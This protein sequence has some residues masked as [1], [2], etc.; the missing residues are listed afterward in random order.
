MLILLKIKST[1]LR[2]CRCFRYERNQ[3]EF[4]H[5]NH[6]VI[7]DKGKYILFNKHLHLW[8]LCQYL[9]QFDRTHELENRDENQITLSCEY[10]QQNTTKSKTEKSI[11]SSI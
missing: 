2:N 1:H 9:F 8:F 4:E 7:A 3:A 5:Y 11:T 6:F 10:I